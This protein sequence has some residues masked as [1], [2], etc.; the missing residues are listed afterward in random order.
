MIRLIF[1]SYDLSQSVRQNQ[2]DAGIED[3]S[4]VWILGDFMG[5]IDENFGLRG[6]YIH[7]YLSFWRQF[8]FIPFLAFVVILLGCS[9]KI[10]K[11]W[12]ANKD[13]N[14]LPLFLFCFTVFALLEIILARSFVYPYIWMSIGGINAYFNYDKDKT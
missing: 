4:S 7:N 8:G 13:V 5:D 6:N 1:G 12:I 10:F 11:Y 2:L 9:F 14:G 3:L